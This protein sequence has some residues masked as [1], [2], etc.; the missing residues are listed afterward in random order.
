MNTMNLG[1]EIL[2]EAATLMIGCERIHSSPYVG[3]YC[4]SDF[5]NITSKSASS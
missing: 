5:V 3:P 2:E 1:R 4:G